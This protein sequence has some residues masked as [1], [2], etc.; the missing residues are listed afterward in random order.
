MF[1]DRIKAVHIKAIWLSSIGYKSF[2][3]AIAFFRVS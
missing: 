2:V 3:F 1:S